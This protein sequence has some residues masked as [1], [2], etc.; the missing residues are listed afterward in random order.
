MA[1]TV[2]PNARAGHTATVIPY[3]EEREAILVLGGFD[4]ENVL[5]LDES[6]VFLP[7]MERWEP[8]PTTS[9]PPQPRAM[10]AAAMMNN[11]LVVHGG[12]GGIDLLRRDTCLLHLTDSQSQWEAPSQRLAL[13]ATPSARQGHS[14]LAAPAEADERQLASSGI[15]PHQPELLLFGGDTG[16]DVSGELWSLTVTPDGQQLVWKLLGAR[17]AHGKPPSARTGHTALILPTAGSG[18]APGGHMLI[19]G[20]R[21]ADGRTFNDMFLFSIGGRRWSKPRVSGDV[22][23]PVSYTHLT[24]PTILL[25]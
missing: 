14:L 10:H 18:V 9:M 11:T 7:S 19:F 25:V 3:R 8:M 6:Y 23:R 1:A 22:P 20:G 2:R 24:L 15:E 4:G 21:A 13:V 5:P 12:W 16:Y 17:E